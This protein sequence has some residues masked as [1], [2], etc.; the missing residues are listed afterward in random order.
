MTPM[1]TPIA[2]VRKYMTECPDTIDDD[3]FLDDARAQMGRRNVR[4][5][6]VVHDD[7]L[8]GIVSDR[9]V[10]LTD[11][12]AKERPRSQPL[13]VRDAMNEVVFSCGPDAH[14]H[15]VAAEMARMR[16]GSAVIVER[17]H[18]LRIVGVFTTTDALRALAE[19]APQEP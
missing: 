2:T 7:V 8:V 19:L 3:A 14:L 4:H 10:N 18:P 15:A 12:V 1:N 9:D 13:L 6:P 5:L 16:I 11:A 17:E